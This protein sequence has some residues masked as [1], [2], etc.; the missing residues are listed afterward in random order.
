MDTYEAVL[1][2]LGDRTRR[3]IVA[4][5]RRGPASVVELAAQVPVSRPAISQ[6]L[7]VL[8]RSRL[9]A[10][11]EVGTRNVY[12]LDP[13]GLDDLGAWLDGFWTT[14]LDRYAARVRRDKITSRRRASHATRGTHG[15]G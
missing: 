8:R 5:L 14:A 13:A 4:S 10:Y 1:D 15:R 11:E 12:R 6:H 7:Q 3:K 9:V 2:A